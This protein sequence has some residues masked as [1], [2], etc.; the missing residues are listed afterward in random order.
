MEF[1]KP[2]LR[3][4]KYRTFWGLYVLEKCLALRLGRASLL[5]DC[6]ISLPRPENLQGAGGLWEDEGPWIIFMA[7]CSTMGSSE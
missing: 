6:D 4:L 5:Q 3:K 1:D 2:A 7:Y